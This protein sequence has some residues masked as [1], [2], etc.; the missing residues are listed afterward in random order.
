MTDLCNVTAVILAGGMGTRLRTV[1]A[2]RQKT[3]AE[4]NGRPFLHYLLEQLSVAGISNV[5]LC[6]GYMAGNVQSLLGENYKQIKLTYSAETEPLGTGGAIRLA[7]PLFKSDPILVMNGDSY[8]DLD[9]KSFAE[10]HYHNKAHD[11][12][13]LATVNDIS[14][15]GAVDLAENHSVTRF[16]EKGQR[17][18]NGLINAG[19][20]LLSRKTIT[21]IPTE[22]AVSL[23]RDIFPNLIGNGLYGFPTD[24]RFIDIGIPEDYRS[25]ADFFEYLNKNEETS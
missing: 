9:L 22:T 5:I 17:Q 2:D 7:L 15:Y 10:K 6:T 1:V 8:F 23:E 20:Y 13:A 4:V 16:E 3:V 12:L 21:T 14:R 18:G 24:G 25:A 11:S 19:I